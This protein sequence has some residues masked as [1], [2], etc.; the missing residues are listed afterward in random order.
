MDEN[1]YKLCFFVPE[2]HLESVKNALFEQGAGQF[3]QYDRCS[4]QTLGVQQFRPL[5]GSKPFIGKENQSERV[6]EYKVE[7][8]C[9]A[10]VIQQ[11]LLALI[12]AHPYELPAYEVYKIKRYQDFNKGIP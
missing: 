11:A 7:M 1:L 3:L 8:V 9:R 2:S 4:W 5:P 6:P 10:A 12:A